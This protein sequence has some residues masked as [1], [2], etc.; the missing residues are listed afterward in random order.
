M[1]LVEEGVRIPLLSY[2]LGL[3]IELD[4]LISELQ[5]L[6]IS[7]LNMYKIVQQS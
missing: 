7:Y 2:F 3:Y 5:H 4:T 6:L 1:A